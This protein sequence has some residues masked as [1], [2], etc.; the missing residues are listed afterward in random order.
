MMTAE[1]VVFILDRLDAAGVAA[2]LDGGWAVDAALGEV[3]RPHEDLDL[4]IELGDVA[5]MRSALAR[6]GF[7]L[8]RGEAGSN[9]VLRDPRTREVDVHPVR[10]DPAGDGIYRM[11]NGEDWT[12]PGEGVTGMGRVAGRDVRCLTPDVQM[13]GHSTGYEPD[14]IDVQDMRL[15]HERLGA[16]LRPP[17]D[18]LVPGA[19]RIRPSGRPPASA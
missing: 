14:V 9:F 15:L 12:Y 17:F 7:D 10:F 2:W 1:D 13:L 16:A 6:H 5:R 8:V 3:T 11:E 4:I 18:R 19:D